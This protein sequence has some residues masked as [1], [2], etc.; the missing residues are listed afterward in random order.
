MPV[1]IEHIVETLN[2]HRA[3][4]VGYAWVVVGD[5]QLADDIY[6]DVSLAAIKKHDQIVDD[7]HLMPWLR[8]AI[9]LRGFEVRRSR[10]AQSHL[11]SPEV[12]DLFESTRTDLSQVKEGDRMASLRR[13]I[14]ALP[15]HARQLLNMRYVEDLKPQQIAERTGKSDQA[16]YKAIKRMH[17]LL[18]G[19]IKERLR[20]LGVTP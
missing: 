11:L 8:T 15:D 3:A 9:R 19:C 1:S 10:S 14:E 7:A 12:L 18:S 2:Q 4:M 16:V 6:Q 17:L 20:A 13:C 5:A